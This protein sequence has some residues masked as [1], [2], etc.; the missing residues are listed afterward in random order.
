MEPSTYEACH[1][2]D[3]VKSEDKSSYSLTEA[4]LLKDTARSIYWY[5]HMPNETMGWL[6][7][8][9]QLVVTDSDATITVLCKFAK[10]T[11]A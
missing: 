1:N 9:Q 5:T 10:F 6:R 3:F 11:G 8:S 4:K 7:G 2:H